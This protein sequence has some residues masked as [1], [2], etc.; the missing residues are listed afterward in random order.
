MT[1]PFSSPVFQK[2]TITFQIPDPDAAPTLERGNV[3][4]KMIPFT[5][6]AKLGAAGGGRNKETEASDRNTL[7]LEGR[8]VEPAVLPLSLRNGAEGT[9]VY[10]GRLGEAKLLPI[11]QG[12]IVP[13]T[14]VLGEKIKIE[15]REKTNWGNA[16]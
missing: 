4:R 15:Y 11:A 12:T 10:N 13:A 5:V 2:T 16:S 8:C 3:K 9:A 14:A 1:T 6:V 7:I